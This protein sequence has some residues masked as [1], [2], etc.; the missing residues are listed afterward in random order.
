MNFDPL[1]PEFM[2]QAE[3][4]R[5]TNQALIKPL[6]EIKP[7]VEMV[8]F[9]L[10]PDLRNKL[11]K[12]K[13]VSSVDIVHTICDRILSIRKVPLSSINYLG[14]AS[15]HFSK[16]SYLTPERRE[17]ALLN[18]FEEKYVTYK[19]FV[20]A[21]FT[22]RKRIEFFTEGPEYHINKNTSKFFVTGLGAKKIKLTRVKNRS[23]NEETKETV[24]NFD[25]KL[26]NNELCFV[27]VNPP[28]QLFF[29]GDQNPYLLNHNGS[30][31]KWRFHGLE[32]VD[33]SCVWDPSYR[34]HLTVHKILTKLF[35]DDYTEREKNLF[36]EEYFKTV[37]VNFSGYSFNFY[38]RYHIQQ[39]YH[40]ENYYGDDNSSPLWNSCM[41]YDESS[42]YLAFYEIIPQVSIAVLMKEGAVVARSLIWEVD[43][44]KYF[45]RVY[46]YDVE[47]EAII[48]YFLFLNNC[49]R[50]RKT[51]TSEV[52]FNFNLK[53]P[54]DYSDFSDVDTY[55]YV[56]SFR[57]YYPHLGVL[58]NIEDLDNY[59]GVLDNTDG[60]VSWTD[61]VR[62]E[63]DCCGGT[64]L[65]D[66]IHY[67]HRGDHR[68]E[69]LCSDCCVYSHYYDEYIADS[70]A[71]VCDVT[72]NYILEEESVTLLNGRTC[73]EDNPGLIRLENDCGFVHP[74]V[75]EEG[76]DYFEYGGLYYSVDD[77]EYLD[78]T[79]DESDSDDNSN[80]ESTEEL[81]QEPTVEP[82]EEPQTNLPPSRFP[83]FL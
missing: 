20:E 39:Y 19:T 52:E 31:E 53:I 18:T 46:Y 59:V 37:I 35:G 11:K 82:S 26:D 63:C 10:S 13:Q 79:S 4:H 60:E 12:L 65:E 70:D 32:T 57:W 16:I 45:D 7:K 68:R 9:Y 29:D 78:M 77:P 56:D 23:V 61:E 2:Q 54:L 27:S 17:R 41:R 42:D 81:S 30:I 38:N 74:S 5:Q 76:E 69:H 15:E 40:Y 75:N 80:E 36:A 28:L 58:S 71:V 44:V 21:V 49:K 3:T 48:E 22:E 55:P 64:V 24:I 14:L 83:D 50:L 43:N 67:I 72:N 8:K 33:V 34:H 1:S 25:Y 51:N 73:H 6:K 47:A 66:N 62:Q